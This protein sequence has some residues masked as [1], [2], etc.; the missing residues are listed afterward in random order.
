M[1]EQY[2]YVVTQVRDNDV[3]KGQV[4]QAYNAKNKWHVQW[5]TGT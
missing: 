1:W 5:P 3:R 4:G 2:Q